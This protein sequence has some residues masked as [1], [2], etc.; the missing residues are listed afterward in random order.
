MTALVP[1]ALIESSSSFSVHDS[2]LTSPY[3]LQQFIFSVHHFVFTFYK[4]GQCIL[5]CR[6]L[7]NQHMQV[8]IPSETTNGTHRVSGALIK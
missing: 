8:D 2:F 5:S 6:T 1:S 7:K 4:K 3:I